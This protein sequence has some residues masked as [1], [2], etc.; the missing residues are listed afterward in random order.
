VAV[1][2]Y[3][4]LSLGELGRRLTETA[5]ELV[6]KEIAL[7]KQEGRE[8]LKQNVRAAIW[9]AAGAALLLCALIC[10]LIALTAVTASIIGG[11]VW[12]LAAAGGI[13]LLIFAVGGAV[14]LFVGKGRLQTHPLGLTRAEVKETV[15][16]AKQRLTPPAK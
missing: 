14:C 6:R 2:D 16:W 7:A 4:Q 3:E 5:R 8:N 9:L 10:L 15:E 13:W 1:T 12:R 11:G